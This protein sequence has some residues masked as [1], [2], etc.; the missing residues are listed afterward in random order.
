MRATLDDPTLLQHEDDVRVSYRAE[1]VRDDDYR[2][3]GLE[4]VEGLHHELL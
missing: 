3:T 4:P 1:P 2:T